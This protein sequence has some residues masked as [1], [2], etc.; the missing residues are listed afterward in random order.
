MLDWIIWIGVF[1]AS[2]AML[3]KSSDFF[4]DSAEKIG[5][6]LGM[7]AFIVGVTVVAIGTSLPELASSISA[8]LGGSTEMVVSNVVGSNIANIFLVLGLTAV[9]AGK[10]KTKYDLGKVDLPMMV[11]SAFLLAI[12]AWDGIL[13]LM[14]AT[15]LIAA[16]AIYLYY[17]FTIQGTN[18]VKNE[19]KTRLSL[20]NFAI[21]I[22]SAALIYVGAKYTVESLLA[23]SKLANIGTDVLTITA[24]ALGTSLPE[25]VVSVKAARKGRADMALGNVLG[26]NVF[27]TLAVMGIPAILGSLVIPSSIISLG[28]PVMIISTIMYFVIAQDREITEWE[29]WFLVMFYALFIIKVMELL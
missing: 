4:V 20:K 16:L 5:I 6:A 18:P 26:S 11:G 29:G 1:V 2:L 28:L 7:P 17:M 24:L 13:T 10:L 21:L 3:I 22:I 9:F 27:N 25:L 8:V 19:R 15:V 14:E 12:T 23:F